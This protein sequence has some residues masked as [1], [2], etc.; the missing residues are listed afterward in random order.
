MQ[1]KLPT[2]RSIVDVGCDQGYG[3]ERSPEDELPPS[4][5][6]MVIMHQ[7]EIHHPPWDFNKFIDGCEYDFITKGETSTLLEYS[8]S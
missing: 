1:I 5:P 7:P 3:S 2:N 8:H 4:L 6:L